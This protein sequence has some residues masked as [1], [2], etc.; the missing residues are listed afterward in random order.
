MASSLQ[1]VLDPETLLEAYERIA[2]IHTKD[3]LFAYYGSA[4]AEQ[5]VGSTFE[6]VVFSDTS[7]AAGINTRGAPARTLDLEGGEKK[8]LS[9]IHSFNEVVIPA[10]QI[11]FLREPNTQ[12]VQ[13]RG[14]AEI[15]RQL[16]LFAKKNML[17]RQ[18]SLAHAFRGAIY[19]DSA[20]LPLESSSGA[21]TT[22]DLGVGATHKTQ[23]AHASN[24]SA[25]IIGT[26]WDQAGASILTDLEQIR[27][28]AEYDNVPVPSH[29]WLHA[30]AKT[31]ILSNT[32][33]KAF[34]QNNNPQADTFLKFFAGMGDTLS[35]GDWTFHFTNA[36][37]I[38]A[39]GTT[40]RPLIPKT[41]AIITPDVND[42]DW[43]ANINAAE[44]V[45]TEDG[46][47]ASADEYFSKTKTVFGTFV[48]ARINDNPLK[49][50]LR[51]GDNFLYAFKEPNA[52]WYPT[53][54]F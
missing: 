6:F 48:Y 29:V 54:D 10:E 27:E 24:A 1:S 43:F 53:V 49:V 42:G 50:A 35:I 47:I 16:E 34:V 18:V 38:G 52:V 13:D 8:T 4:R 40:R 23:L 3:P 36:T 37:Y 7:K 22:V 32:E 15:R 28:A 44:T 14:M 33:I 19:F 39:D 17:L 26:A 25:D 41:A 31:W 51:M 2:S 5:A 45:P 20:G 46:L 12:A 9:T 30:A 11:E 21:V